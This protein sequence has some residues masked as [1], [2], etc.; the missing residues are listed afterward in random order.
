VSPSPPTRGVVRTG[1]TA[2]VDRTAAELAASLDP[3][4][5]SADHTERGGR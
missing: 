1:S 3:G 4:V 5:P 2:D